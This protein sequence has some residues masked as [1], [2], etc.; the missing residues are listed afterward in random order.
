M[1]WSKIILSQV[2]LLFF[3]SNFTFP[4]PTAA[5]TTEEND[6]ILAQ[7][8]QVFS[9]VKLLLITLSSCGQNCQNADIIFCWSSSGQSRALNSTW[10]LECMV[11]HYLFI[12]ELSRAAEH[13]GYEN[14]VNYLSE[15][16]WQS[17]DRT[18]PAR[19]IGIPTQNLG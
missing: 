18:P 6:E 1:E 15:D 8:L 3:C 14:V 7:E 13:H 4:P 9:S 11:Y 16:I 12:T 19:T 10:F 17:R 2:L 5:V